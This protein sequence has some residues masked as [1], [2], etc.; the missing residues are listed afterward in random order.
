LLEQ[1]EHKT[2]KS[3]VN[4]KNHEVITKVRALKLSAFVEDLV[5]EEFPSG[6]NIDVDSGLDYELCLHQ[7]YLFMLRQRK[8]VQLQTS[9]ASSHDSSLSWDERPLCP[10]DIIL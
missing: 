3:L 7:D 4:Y 8:K 1:R 2:R 9:V 10:Q 6:F 5:K